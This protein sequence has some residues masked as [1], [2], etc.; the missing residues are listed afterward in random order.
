MTDS[1]GL[2]QRLDNVEQAIL[3]L[4]ELTMKQGVEWQSQ[5]TLQALATK[6]RNARIH[7]S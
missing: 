2:E 4:M 3:A 1:D 7:E 6:I 5:N